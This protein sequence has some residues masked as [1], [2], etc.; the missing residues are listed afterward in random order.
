MSAI[1]AT[2]WTGAGGLRAAPSARGSRRGTR[3]VRLG[4]GSRRFHAEAASL[5][6]GD[7]V[8]DG[9]TTARGRWSSDRRP[10]WRAAVGAT[11]GGAALHAGSA[12][13]AAFATAPPATST[14][15]SVD[16]RI[17]TD[18]GVR[19][20]SALAPLLERLSV[21]SSPP[22]S[23]RDPAL[24]GDVAFLPAAVALPARVGSSR[25]GSPGTRLGFRNSSRKSPVSS[26]Q[27]GSRTARSRSSRAS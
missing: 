10:G 20:A 3:V 16:G 4:V 12:A 2:G 11:I 15:R 25:A 22:V 26:W 7:D 27:T 13:P 1:H 24:V 23:P 6:P 9:T 17:G 8:G 14:T 21:T 19:D 18:G 5:N